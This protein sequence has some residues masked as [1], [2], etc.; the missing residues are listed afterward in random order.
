[1]AEEKIVE[2]TEKAADQPAESGDRPTE[3]PRPSPAVAPASRARNQTVMLSPELTGQVRN[4]LNNPDGASSNPDPLSELLPPM[5]WDRPSGPGGRPAAGNSSKPAVSNDRTGDLTSQA[6][7]TAGTRKPTGRMN[8]RSVQPAPSVTNQAT[9]SV[10]PGVA[11]SGSSGA[12]PTMRAASMR[13]AELQR[14]ARSRIVGFLISFDKNQF[15]EV[16]EIRV[17]RFLLSSKASEHGDAI[18]IDDESI[19]PLHAIVRAAD[20]GRVQVLD[21]LSEF[22]TG[23]TRA[24]TDTEEEVAGAMVSLSHGDLIRFGKRQFVVCLVPKNP[25]EVP[26]AAAG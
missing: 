2:A 11:K 1:M 18:V 25:K 16:F 21:Q 10:N 20:D 4:M 17:G 22:G 23:V 24:G 14:E 5:N 26:E 9:F 13:Q 3:K 15:G 19:S 7:L 12:Q 8:P 6:D